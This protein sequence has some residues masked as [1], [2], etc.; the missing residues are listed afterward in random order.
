MG[1]LYMNRTVEMKDLIVVRDTQYRPEVHPGLLYR[2]ALLGLSDEDMAA[3]MDVDIKVFRRWLR[4]YPEMMD[5]Y[6]RGTRVADGYVA[7]ALYRSAVGYSCPDEKYM[8]KGKELVKVVT[9]K[10]YPPNVHAAIK[11]LTTRLPDV[12]NT[13]VPIKHETEDSVKV[14]L[15]QFTD[16]E[17]EVL[18]RIGHAV[19][20]ST[21][22]EH[23]K[24]V[25]LTRK[26]RTTVG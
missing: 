8:M 5:A 1:E 9:T 19:A 12:W 24:R 10:Y 16:E 7:E 2:S 4:K 11:I 14:D 25:T 20:A 15:S 17:L 26:T 13:T 18:G 23:D 21:N 6:R 22:K 3:L